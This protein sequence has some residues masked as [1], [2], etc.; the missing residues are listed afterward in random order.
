M[1]ERKD[2]RLVLGGPITFNDAL[3]WREAVLKEIDRD[4]L[5]IDL[6]GVG[7]AD[8][9]ALSLLLEWRREAKLRG[10]G[11]RYANLPAAIRS[12]AEV[13]GIAALIPTIDIPASHPA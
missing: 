9:A 8:S 3:E 11:L 1:I 2:D 4:G 5:V 12:L 7:E 10:Y 13:Y 6:S